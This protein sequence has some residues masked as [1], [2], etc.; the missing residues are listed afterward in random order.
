[1]DAEIDLKAIL[2]IIRRQLWLVLST[3]LAVIAIVSIG[4]FSV[5]PRYT[6]TALV[7]V[8]T[9]DKN[10]LDTGNGSPNSTTDNARVESEVEILKSERVLVGVIKDQNLVTDTEFGVKVGLKD[11]IFTMLRLPVSPAPDGDALLTRVIKNFETA[12]SIKRNG[13]TYLI[14][15]GVQS[16]DPEKAARL[17]NALT[18]AYI[19]EQIGSKVSS[20]LIARDTLQK[21]V[22]AANAT[23]AEN[24]KSFD[25][26][27]DQNL[28]RIQEQAGGN[29]A[30]GDLRTQLDKIS[31]SQVAELNRLDA[32]RHAVLSQDFDQMATSLGSDALAELQKQRSDLSKKIASAGD[33]SPTAVDLRAELDKVNAT[34]QAQAEAGLGDLQKTVSG[35]QER[36]D[37]LRQEIRSTV[38]KSNLPPQVLTEIYSLQKSAEIARNQYQN[39]LQRLQDL[40]AQTDLQLPDSRVVSSALAPTDTS[41]P[42]KPLILGV[43]LVAALGLGMALAVL[44]EYFIG[45]FVSESQVEAVLRTQLS[46]V[47]PRQSGNDELSKAGGYKSISDLMVNAPLSQFSE[48]IRRLRLALD[49]NERRKLAAPKGDGPKGRVIM[50][51]SALPNEGKSTVALSVARAYA[52]TGQRT[53]LIDCDLRK[54]SINKHLN[55][56]PNPDF[57]NYLKE[58]IGTSGLPS[59]TTRD[60]LSNLTVL[61]GGGRSNMATDELVMSEK[62]SRL[63]IS[64]RKHFDYIV[65]DTPPVE[66]VVD[67]LYLARQADMVVFVVKWAS[68]PQSSAKRAIAALRENKNPEAEII[69]ILNQQD[70]SKLTSYNAYTG[71]YHE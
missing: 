40:D 1:M 61:V 52:L 37:A 11:K 23:I 20:T 5:T 26:Y 55:L 4:V 28:T 24:E 48:S 13:L 2:G 30:I 62:M 65:L 32:A 67:G 27:L 39:L 58:G 57:L 53:L 60:P 42:N 14:S 9:K 31:Q 51:S 56:E 59:L 70:R 44:R 3:V 47:A 38:L 54:P 69:T 50:V 22:T 18:D 66:P 15:V 33:G 64:A 21:R 36:G 8:D 35:Y 6:A 16:Q 17:V 46:T 41:F 19:R 25:S 43:A 45:G 63:L 68:T 7:L 12:I 49:Q 71:Y 10:L 34:F 29:L